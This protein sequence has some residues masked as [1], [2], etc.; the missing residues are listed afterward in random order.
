MKSVQVLKLILNRRQQQH[1]QQTQIVRLYMSLS[2]VITIRVFSEAQLFI[3][4]SLRAM[5]GGVEGSYLITDGDNWFRNPAFGW[6]TPP[7]S[8]A[9]CSKSLVWVCL[10]IIFGCNYPVF[11]LYQYMLHGGIQQQP[12][13]MSSPTLKIILDY[14]AMSV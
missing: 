9:R 12:L 14:P 2:N 1:Q 8:L 13:A 11:D 6:T 5:I 10:I 7:P 4:I 3:S